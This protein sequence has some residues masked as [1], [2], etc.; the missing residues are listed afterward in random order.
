MGRGNGAASATTIQIAEDR[1]HEDNPVD[2]P[3]ENIST[4][5]TYQTKS[6]RGSIVHFTGGNRY[7]CRA[8]CLV[9]FEATFA[10]GLAI[11]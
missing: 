9:E 1:T 11:W 10:I 7:L 8:T 3:L 4:R 5:G 2:A 6:L